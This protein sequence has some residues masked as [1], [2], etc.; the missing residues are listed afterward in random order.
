MIGDLDESLK[1]YTI[2]VNLRAAIPR[3]D[4]RG[5]RIVLEEKYIDPPIRTFL[6]TQTTY[7]IGTATRAISNI[8][9]CNVS[10]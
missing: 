1:N 9:K 2:P 3:V 10:I 5:N 7:S 6:R 8:L 4:F